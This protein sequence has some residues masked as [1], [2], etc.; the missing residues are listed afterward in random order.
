MKTKNSA[1][2]P[3]GFTA[4]GIS[5]GI[6]KS[7]KLD[8]ALFYSASPCVAAGMFTTNKVAAAPVVLCRKNLASG[9]R[10]HAV[11][12]NSGNANCFTFA[13]GLSDAKRMAHSAAACLGVSDT[14]VF[15]GSTGIIGKRLPAQKVE[16]AMPALAQS[17]SAAGIIDASRAIMTTD[18]FRKEL[19]AQVTIG[20][21]T[22]TVCGVAKGAGMISPTMATMLSFV[23]TD[24]A[25]PQAVLK[26]AL[27]ASVSKSYN[28]ITVD[29]CMSTNDTVI[30]LAN[31]CAGNSPIKG[32]KGLALFQQAL[33]AVN[34]ALAKLMVRDGEGASKFIEI[35]VRGAVSEDDARKACLA[36]ANSNLFKTAVYGENPNFGRIVQAVGASGCRMDERRLKVRMGPLTG[37]DVWVEASLSMGKASCTVY[38]SDLTPEYIK[39]NA[40]YN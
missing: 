11:V 36:I 3:K 26:K 34:L 14:S 27:K 5:S 17:L 37:K 2:L 7:G 33:D 24:A 15:V 19:T 12:A 23:F 25:I 8:L 32:G 1:V 9:K 31:G 6:K 30:C 10:F 13:A 18:K 38:A 28:R 4:A 20:G 29:G 22:V 39:I 21:K 40:A 16:Q 35:T